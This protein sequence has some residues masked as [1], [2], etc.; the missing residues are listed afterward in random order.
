[1]LTIQLDVVTAERLLFSKHVDGVVVPGDMGELTVLPHHAPLLTT[2]K[3]GEL[4]VINGSEESHIAVSSGF[5][6]VMGNKVTVLADTA[7]RSGEI[8]IE[9]AEEAFKK[10]HE[11]MASATNDADLEKALASIRRSQARI[12]V[13]RR[14][15]KRAM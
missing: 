3:S 13:A 14:R 8:N 12:K 15:R 11:E 6:E 7:E 10:A 2:L 1:M 4:R 9:R 5:M